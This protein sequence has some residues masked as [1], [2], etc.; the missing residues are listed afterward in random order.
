MSYL[1]ILQD[2]KCPL[3]FVS[4]IVTLYY[5]S[6]SRYKK[7]TCR[8]LPAVLLLD[9]CASAFTSQVSAIDTVLAKGTHYMA[10]RGDVSCTFCRRDLVDTSKI[11]IF[12]Y[13]V[14][15]IAQEGDWS[16]SF[17]RRIFIVV[18]EGRSRGIASRT[19]RDSKAHLSI[20]R[21]DKKSQ[22]YRR[23]REPR[24]R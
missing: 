9:Y 13:L 12:Y 14:F 11:F 7:S 22:H 24:R 19:T 1:E 15:R 18:M 23:Q 16:C 8:G 10:Q 3:N 2:K 21:A 20:A 17:C 5:N 4:A 6:R